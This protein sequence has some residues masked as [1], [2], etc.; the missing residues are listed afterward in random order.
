MTYLESIALMIN[1]RHLMVYATVLV[2][3][4]QLYLHIRQFNKC[5]KG[6]YEKYR[7]FTSR[8]DMS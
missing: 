3:L 4:V 5:R 6:K 8:I 2:H 1:Y 7:V